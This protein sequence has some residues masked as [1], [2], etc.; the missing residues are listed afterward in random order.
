VAQVHA[1]FPD[2]CA[3][4]ADVAPLSAG[5]KAAADSLTLG[6]LLADVAHLKRELGAVRREVGAALRRLAT[7]DYYSSYSPL[8]ARGQ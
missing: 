2:A 3:F 8:L 4:V 1:K 6:G 7:R 5:G